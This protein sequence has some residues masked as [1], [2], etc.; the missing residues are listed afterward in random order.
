[1]TDSLPRIELPKSHAP[2]EWRR[3][4]AELIE[5]ARTVEQWAN[6]CHE[7]AVLAVSINETAVLQLHELLRNGR[8]KEA[9]DAASEA[10]KIIN[11]RRAGNH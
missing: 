8:V 11:A 2:D 6:E 5:R 7:R 10:A 4:V 3:T 1:M 9:T